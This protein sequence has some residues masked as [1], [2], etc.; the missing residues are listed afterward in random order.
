VYPALTKKIR[1]PENNKKIKRKEL[2]DL[3]ILPSPST[4]VINIL[5][6]HSS[7]RKNS[8]K[9]PAPKKNLDNY[10]QHPS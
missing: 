5:G 1:E 7:P 8:K 3:L 2:E 6:T 10:L 4:S 9:P